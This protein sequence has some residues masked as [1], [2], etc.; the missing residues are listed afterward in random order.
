MCTVASW[1]AGCQLTLQSDFTQSDRKFRA[2]K[3]ISYAVVATDCSANERAIRLSKSSRRVKTGA[4]NNTSYEKL[5]DT[6]IDR[7]FVIN[8]TYSSRI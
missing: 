6:W 7:S 4:E 3:V 5:S 1:R 2:A 8:A